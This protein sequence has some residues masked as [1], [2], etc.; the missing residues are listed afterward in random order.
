[1]YRLRTADKGK[2]LLISDAVIKEY[3][4]CYVDTLHKKNLLSLGEDR[5]LTT[6]M[7]KHFP[8]MTY[9]FIPD[10]FALTAAPETW[11]VLLS[12][13]RRWIN[14]TI[15]NLFELFWLKDMCGFCC[16]SMRFVV[17]IDLFGTIILPSTVG[18]IIY[19][20]W[21][22]TTGQGQFPTI[23]ICMIAATYGLQALIFLLKRQ[24]QHIGWMIIY[25]LAFPVYS[26]IL[27]VYSFW[28]QDNFSWGNTRIVIGEK[29]SKQIIALDDEGFDPRSV[30]LLTWDH[31]ATVNN[32]PGRRGGAM[33]EKQ[34]V[35][36]P[37]E[38]TYELDEMKS[39]YSSVKPAST[40]LSKGP[41]ANVYAAPQ[42]PTPYAMQQRQSQYS[43][44]PYG[45]HAAISRNQ[46]AMSLGHDLRVTSPYQDNPYRGSAL[47]PS[48]ENLLGGMNSPRIAYGGGRSLL[49]PISRP[50]S[51][52]DFQ[53]GNAG[54]DD[55]MIVEAIRNCLS[56]VDL[57]SVTKKQVRALVE[58][59]LQ[60]ELSGERRTFLDRMID[61]EL[62]AM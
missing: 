22:V 23:S 36:N 4:D 29:G 55:Q 12:Q 59:R 52:F 43:T 28:N 51:T 60:S 45:D 32:L 41:Y 44:N 25:L 3:S 34:V 42:T 58:Q 19:L 21:S 40:I 53:R 30:P 47:Y 46:S 62:A 9:K 14:S 24:W 39:M 50:V 1:M 17:L 5:F 18:Y 48:S 61:S 31:Y 54:P 20:I 6:L 11:S 2:P 56:E 8:Y 7:T 38:D 33:A 15:H 57:D 16:F 35:D 13:R 26:L 27:P 37:Y 10:A 49:D